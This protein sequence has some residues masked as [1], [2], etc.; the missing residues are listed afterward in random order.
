MLSMSS[1]CF[2]T[3]FVDSVVTCEVGIVPLLSLCPLWSLEH[4]KQEVLTVLMK[5]CIKILFL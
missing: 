1:L 5:S 3:L 2:H 4:S